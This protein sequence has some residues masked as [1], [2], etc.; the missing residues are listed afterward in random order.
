MSVW[1]DA[2]GNTVG[3]TRSGGAV[4]LQQQVSGKGAI[5][6]SSTVCASP[7]L[8]MMPLVLLVLRR[9]PTSA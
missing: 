6:T 5:V 2:P 7:L 9:T 1:S 8:D 3:S 4:G